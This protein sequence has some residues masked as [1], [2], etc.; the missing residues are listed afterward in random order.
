MRPEIRQKQIDEVEY[1]LKR[2]WY[3][4][5]EIFLQN[6]KLEGYTMTAGKIKNTYGVNKKQ[7]E[8]T[9]IHYIIIKNP[10]YKCAA[11][12]KCYL[13]RE[14]EDKLSIKGIRRRKLNELLTD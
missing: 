2:K 9:K 7:L 8:K 6:R 4:K 14:V 11:P 3:S 13:I 10:H 12:M 1:Y 5:A